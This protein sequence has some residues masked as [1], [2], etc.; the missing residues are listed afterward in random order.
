MSAL[1]LRATIP[2][3]AGIGRL[4]APLGQGPLGRWDR[5]NELVLDIPQE[6]FASQSDIAALAG[7]GAL[8]VEAGGSW[9]LI[10]Y[11]D[12]ELIGV[13]QYRLTHLLRG[14]QGTV[15]A[16]AEPGAICVKLDNRLVLGGILPGETGVELSW[17]AVAAGLESDLIQSV[18]SGVSTRPF[19]PVHLRVRQGVDLLSLSWVRRGI[20]VNDSWP[21]FEAPNTGL[22]YVDIYRGSDIVFAETTQLAHLEVSFAV[23][24][25]DVVH[26][27]EIASTGQRG[28]P[29]QHLL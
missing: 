26:V 21:D 6:V 3:R 2:E 29:A 25:G 20:E 14:L 18:Y 15:P 11:R 9:E 24:P 12:A 17:S 10:G 13:G 5:A 16:A 4:I 8:L 22:F 1:S 7:T 28:L 23:Q 27:G 19:S